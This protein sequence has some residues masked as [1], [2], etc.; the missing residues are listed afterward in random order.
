MK[1]LFTLTILLALTSCGKQVV[2]KTVEN[3]FDNSVND[4]RFEAQGK[5]LEK[6]VRDL[7]VT[8]D[9]FGIMLKELEDRSAS[10]EETRELVE[11][12]DSIGKMIEDL[13]RQLDELRGR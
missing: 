1:T 13:K 9:K 7:H 4:S 12:I 3:P 8:Q 5:I 10:I 6:P 11:K 2:N